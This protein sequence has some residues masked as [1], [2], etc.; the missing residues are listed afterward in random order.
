[1]TT[2]T[3]AEAGTEH[4]MRIELERRISAP[5]EDVWEAMLHEIGPGFGGENDEPLHMKV[6]PFPG[7]RWYRDLG[8]GTGHLW[9]HVQAIRPHTLF[10]LTGPLFMSA[11]VSNNVQYRLAHQDGVTTLRFVH[12]A[13]GPLPEDLRDGMLEGWGDILDKV[14]HRAGG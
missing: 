12:T 8:D 13:F 9:G 10:E 4:E 7:G 11:P 2:S 6:E 14:E 5:I 1:M 3:M